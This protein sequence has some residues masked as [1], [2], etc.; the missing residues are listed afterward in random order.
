MLY[1]KCEHDLDDELFEEK[2][3][4]SRSRSSDCPIFFLSAHLRP[5]LC[6]KAL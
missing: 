5:N 2:D 3:I 4:V 6:T 1:G